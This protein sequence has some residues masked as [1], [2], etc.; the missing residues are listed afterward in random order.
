MS[1]SAP[2]VDP[3]CAVGEPTHP[4]KSVAQAALAGPA[5][6]SD[7]RQAMMTT[8]YRTDFS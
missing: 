5:K 1:Q 3:L 4:L 2:P 8:K 6:A 7:I